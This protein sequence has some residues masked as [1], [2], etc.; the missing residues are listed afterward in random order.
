M[1]NLSA[2]QKSV[3][4]DLAK[5]AGRVEAKPFPFHSFI[6]AIISLSVLSA[7]IMLAIR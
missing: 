4:Y 5:F 6:K 1:S 7:I 3:D 2:N